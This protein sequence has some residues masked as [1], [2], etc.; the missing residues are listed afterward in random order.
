MSAFNAESS[1]SLSQEIS[2]TVTLYQEVHLLPSLSILEITADVTDV[3]FLGVEEGWKCH[4]QESFV[5]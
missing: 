1:P 4:L 3:A 2:V 5:Y